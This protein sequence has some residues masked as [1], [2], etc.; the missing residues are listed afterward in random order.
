MHLTQAIAYAL[1]IRQ[2]AD[3]RAL[4]IAGEAIEAKGRVRDFEAMSQALKNRIKK[5][6]GVYIVPPSHLL[7]ELV[8]EFQFD[9]AG[10]GLKLA[11]E[12]TKAMRANGTAAACGYPDGWKRDHAL[13]L[14]STDE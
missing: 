5:Y 11:R 10:R 13:K 1:E 9:K 3:R 4:E 6:K 7:D 14:G 12:R 2:R 8:E